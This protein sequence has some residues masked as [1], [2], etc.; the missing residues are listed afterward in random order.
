MKK[1]LFLTIIALLS[2]AL[3]SCNDKVEEPST[4]TVAP[5]SDFEYEKTNSGITITSYKGDD[6]TVVIPEKIEGIAVTVIGEHAFEY[7]NVVETVSMP[8][9]VTNIIHGAFFKDP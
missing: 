1:L 8:D 2:F 5:E 3:L 6:K 7:N 9:T 4:A